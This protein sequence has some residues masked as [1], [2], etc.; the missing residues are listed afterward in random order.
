MPPDPEKLQNSRCQKCQTIQMPL[1][2]SDGTLQKR[3]RLSNGASIR[4][5]VD[6][7]RPACV[8]QSLRCLPANNLRLPL[9]R[10]LRAFLAC[11]RIDPVYRLERLLDLRRVTPAKPPD[12]LPVRQV[13]PERF[14]Q[15][16]I[17]AQQFRNS[18]RPEH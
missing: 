8:V 11:R 14:A 12:V 7:V 5:P 3:G 17:I 13:A 15:L 10:V 2:F 9:G 1:G 16:R 18:P 6:I 4:P